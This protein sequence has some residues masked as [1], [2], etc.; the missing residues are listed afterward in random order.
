MACDSMSCT[1]FCIYALLVVMRLLCGFL[2]LICDTFATCTKKEKKRYINRP[3]LTYR[4]LM[5]ENV[6]DGDILVV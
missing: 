3:M 5:V 1:P 4:Y 6:Q 2:A